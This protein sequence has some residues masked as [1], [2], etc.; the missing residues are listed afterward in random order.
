MCEKPEAE[1]QRISESG[2]PEAEPGPAEIVRYL[3]PVGVVRKLHGLGAE[4][5]GLNP[6]NAIEALEYAEELLQNAQKLIA[7][8]LALWAKDVTLQQRSI[9]WQARRSG[10]MKESAVLIRDGTA[11]SQ[12]RFARH[13]RHVLGGSELYRADVYETDVVLLL[14]MSGS[15]RSESA[16]EIGG[17]RY[18]DN[19][20]DAEKALDLPEGALSKAFFG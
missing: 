12:S 19:W 20:D 16:S 11:I 7:A 14:Y 3:D 9:E 6:D 8:S 4:L 10:G 1:K 2:N 15:G 18:W 17:E 13:I 5:H